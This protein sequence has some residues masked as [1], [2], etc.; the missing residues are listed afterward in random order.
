MLRA[1]GVSFGYG[2]A[3][4]ARDAARGRLRSGASGR[5]HGSPARRQQCGPERCLP[6]RRARRTGRHS[7]TERI[8]QD[9]APQA[10]RRHHRPT[11]GSVTLDDRPVAEW[12]HREIARRIAFVPQET[13]APFDFTRPRHRADGTVSPSR[14]VRARRSRGSGDRAP[15]AHGDRHRAVRRRA[16][17]TLSGGEKQRVVIAS[18]LAQSTQLLLLDEPTAS[19]D[20]GHQI[21]VQLLLQAAECRARA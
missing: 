21:E 4:R 1:T 20:I 3:R 8:R 19:L 7:R 13:H 12:S 11:T 15:R 6:E 10:A 16:F 18:A 5:R 2:R 14:R 9:D 17:S